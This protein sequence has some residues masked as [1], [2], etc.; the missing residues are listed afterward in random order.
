MTDLVALGHRIW[1]YICRGCK[2]SGVLRWVLLTPQKPDPPH[3]DYR[4]EFGH[5][6][7]N[8]RSI[9]SYVP[10]GGLW[11]VSLLKV[12]QRHQ[13]RLDSTGYL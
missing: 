4:V 6:L 9:H 11:G 10:P 7:S 3:M 5:C 12:T 1:T 8:G 13:N 2:K